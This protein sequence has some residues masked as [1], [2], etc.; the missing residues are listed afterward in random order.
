MIL[1]L[2][3]G[4]MCVNAGNNLNGLRIVGFETDIADYWAEKGNPEKY[5]DWLF[6]SVYTRFIPGCICWLVK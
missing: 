5:G 1:T 2:V 4:T 6:E 3:N